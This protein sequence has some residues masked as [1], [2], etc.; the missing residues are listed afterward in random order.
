MSSRSNFI[1]PIKSLRSFYLSSLG[2]FDVDIRQLNSKIIW[3]DWSYLICDKLHRRI[4]KLI[5]LSS[6]WRLLWR[7]LWFSRV[8]FIIQCFLISLLIK[9]LYFNTF[10]IIILL[11]LGVILMRTKHLWDYVIF[12]WRYLF[13]IFIKYM[14]KFLRSAFP[15]LAYLLLDTREVMLGISLN[16]LYLGSTFQ[17]S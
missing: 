14:L 17:I 4:W 13:Y 8:G 2:A 3:Y 7:I 11:F 12:F 10:S 15:L 6:C 16:T 9:T 5:A 1:N